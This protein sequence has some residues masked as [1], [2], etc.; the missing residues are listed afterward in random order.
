LAPVHV[1]PQRHGVLLGGTDDAGTLDQTVHIVEIGA[2]RDG[3]EQRLVVPAGVVHGGGIRR[4]H[5]ARRLGELAD[6]A[7]NRLE[8]LVGRRRLDVVQ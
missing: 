3:M 7:Q 8:S 4:G 1:A 5:P 2:D 6:I